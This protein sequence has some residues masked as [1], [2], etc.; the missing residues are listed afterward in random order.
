MW[1]YMIGILISLASGI[2]GG[3]ISWFATNYYGRNLLRFWEKQL[4]THKALFLLQSTPNECASLWQLAAE[5]DGLRII[6]PKPLHW[7]LRKRGYDLHSAAKGL[8]ELSNRLG[9]GDVSESYDMTCFRVLVQKALRLPCEPT[10]EDLAESRRRL[11]KAGIW[12]NLITG[13][14][15]AQMHD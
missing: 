9:S 10:D 5:I 11:E 2:I 6:L 12:P 15:G 3:I 7:Y 8:I 14:S 4:E 13:H 1:W